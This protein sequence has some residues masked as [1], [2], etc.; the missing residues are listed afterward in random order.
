MASHHRGFA[1]MFRRITLGRNFLLKW[2]ARRRDFYLETHIIHK[3]QTSTPPAGFEP[4]IPAGEWPQTEVLDRSATGTDEI[5]FRKRKMANCRFRWSRGLRRSSAANRL[6]RSW[7]RI[8][9]GGHGCLSVVSVVC[10]QVEVLATR[11][12]L[13]QRSPIDC[14]ASLCV[15]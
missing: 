7:V 3:R 5:T 12:S 13:V 15:I 8:P 14:R 6:L 1:I 4:T 9:P 2:S 11:W 10:C